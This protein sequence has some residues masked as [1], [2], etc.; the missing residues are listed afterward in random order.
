MFK[1]IFFYLKSEE[2]VEV[3]GL[4]ESIMDF[5]IAKMGLLESKENI[6]ICDI[7]SIEVKAP[8]GDW[9]LND[10]YLMY[11]GDLVVRE[12]K[13]RLGGVMYAVDLQNNTDAIGLFFGGD[14]GG[15]INIA[16][17]LIFYKNNCFGEKFKDEFMR[18]LRDFTVKKKGWYVSKKLLKN[19]RLTTDIKMSKDYDLDI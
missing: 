2:L 19:V 5:S 10:K 16:S 9:N 12:I 18:I 13:Q 3:L 15:N 4:I 11:H 17:K 8:R 6:N 14:L 7:S 1:E